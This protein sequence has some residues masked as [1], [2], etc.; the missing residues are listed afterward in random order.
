[1]KETGPGHEDELP[2]GNTQ[3]NA[4]LPEVAVEETHGW[5]AGRPCAPAANCAVTRCWALDTGIP[6]SD[7]YPHLLCHLQERGNSW[8][9]SPT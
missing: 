4:T 3:G 9:L 6:L 2:T 8:L 7:N 1:M 5:R